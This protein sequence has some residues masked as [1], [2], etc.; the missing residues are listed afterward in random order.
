MKGVPCSA[1]S[2]GREWV[3]LVGNLGYSGGRLWCS[4]GREGAGKERGRV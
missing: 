2:A 1:N 3:L 4:G